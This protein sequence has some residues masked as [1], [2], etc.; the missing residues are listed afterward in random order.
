VRVRIDFHGS[1]EPTL[2]V[3]WELALVDRRTRDLR[4]DAAHLFARARPRLERPDRLHQEL[5]K[6]TVELV[7]GICHTV[8][9]AMSD[10]RRTL[11]RV[12]PAGDDLDIDLYGA[13]THP[14]ASW[15]GQQLTEGHRYQELIDR[16]QWWGR[17]M[18][19]WGVHVHVG[20]PERDRVL[21]VLSA[22][23][24]YHPHLQALS[25]SSPIWAG[26]DT[27][28]ASNRA[29]MFQQLPTAGLPFQF[30]TWAEFEAFAQDQ[31]TTGVIDELSE[32]RW[33]LRPAPHLGTLENRVCDGVSDMGELAG[34]VALM[35]CLV[36]DIDT[37]IAAGER[38]P[39][40]PPWHVQENKWRAARYGLDAIIIVD[41]QSHERLLTDDLADL[42]VRLEPVAARLGCLD[43]LA[44]LA[45]LPG[46]GASYQRQRAVAERTGDDLVAV[47]DSVV[48]ELLASL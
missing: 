39:V 34:L 16:T 30:T 18:L 26:V 36:V 3:E 12:V 35:H 31:L 29:L 41:A 7:T 6:N 32:V 25:A 5:L 22:L 19:I 40:L 45:D 48:H 1:A 9:E 14:F 24:N 47:V 44:S 17:Q 13:G 28:Y 38:V 2:G 46:R 37:R 20:L 15:I 43:E 27:G 21:P 23:L 4:N 8:E 10:L 33:D 11:E 42:L